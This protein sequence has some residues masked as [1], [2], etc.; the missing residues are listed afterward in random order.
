[1][2]R[3]GVIS[4][5]RSTAMSV[6][7][8]MG[9]GVWKYAVL[10]S[11]LILFCLTAALGSIEENV[12]G[13]FRFAV[14]VPILAFGVPL[15]SNSVD[16][17]R[18]AGTLDI[19]LTSRG[20][21]FYFEQRVGGLAA[22]FLVQSWL[23]V[24]LL[25]AMIGFH[26]APP[27][28]QALSVC[29]FVGSAGLLWSVMLRSSGAAMIATWVTALVFSKWLFSNPIFRFDDDSGAMDREEFLTWAGANTVLLLAGVIFYLYAVRRL[30]RPEEILT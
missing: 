7:L 1:M 19:A 13:V 14:V 30:S 24:L 25:R 8:L 10:D 20:A 9:R 2:T 4:F 29:L 28:I 22:L 17:E 11:I 21:R 23:M 5:A 6:N 16:L 3:D 27:L 18:R 12:E 15:I 26:V